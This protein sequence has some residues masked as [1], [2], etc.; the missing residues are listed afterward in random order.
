MKKQLQGQVA[1]VT[2]G[3]KG[4]G[5]GVAQ[6]LVAEGCDVVITGRD[7]EALANAT[8]QLQAA[9]GGS[10]AAGSGARRS[11]VEAITV[12]V[13]DHGSITTAV[14]GVAERL[15]GL[16][17]VVN[18]AGV[19]RFVNIAEM[20]PSQWAD[21]IDT[22]LTGVFYVTRA[23]LPHLRQRGGGYIFNVSSLAGKNAFVGAGAYCAS[24]AGLNAF[25]EVLMQEVRHDNIKVTTIAPGSV[26]TGFS[27]GNESAGADW[28]IASSDIGDLVVSLL[29]IDT[30]SLPSYIELR[31]SK[32]PRK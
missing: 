6:A 5:F 22:N 14:N 7:E 19:G 10:A 4:I 30:R 8:R 23:A 21:V 27:G 29:R 26:A 2:G 20:S 31:P 12:D 17:V 24:K 15:G 25:G 11:R 1:L 32:P 18:N 13:R 16:D 28:K 3:S 9:S